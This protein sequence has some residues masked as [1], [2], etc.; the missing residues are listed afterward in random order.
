MTERVERKVSLAR[1]F[2]GA[3]GEWWSVQEVETSAY[4]RR[5]ARSLVFTNDVEMV[6]RRVREYPANWASL[7]DADLSALSRHR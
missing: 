2:R 3:D 7:S 6:M 5:G 4:D 1:S